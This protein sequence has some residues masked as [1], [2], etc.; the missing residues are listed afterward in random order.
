MANSPGPCRSASGLEISVVSVGDAVMRFLT[1]G[2]AGDA[3]VSWL[4]LRLIELTFYPSTNVARA[5]GLRQALV[6]HEL[7]DACCSGHFRLENVGL[8]R[9]QHALRTQA[10]T[11]L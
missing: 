9:K 1:G 10:R 8:A 3:Q 11:H 5:L 4:V 7:G 6:G 2:K